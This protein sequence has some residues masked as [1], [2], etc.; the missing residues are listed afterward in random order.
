MYMYSAGAK[1]DAITFLNRLGLSVS[2]NVLLRKL[3]GIISSSAAF[4]K[5]QASNYKLVGMWDNFEY[6]ENVAGERI[7]DIVKFRSVTMAL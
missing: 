5:E 3:K 2:Y 1:V 7:S 4:I 6:Q